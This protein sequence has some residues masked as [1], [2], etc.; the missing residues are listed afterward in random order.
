TP[1]TVEDVLAPARRLW[2][3]L[4]FAPDRMPE[5]VVVTPACGLA[6]ASQGWARSVTALTRRAARALAESPEGVPR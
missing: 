4:G 2:A 6:G 5:T 3:R 1:P